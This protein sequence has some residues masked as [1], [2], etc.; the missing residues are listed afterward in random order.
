MFTHFIHPIFHQASSKRGTLISMLDESVKGIKAVKASSQESRRADEFHKPNE[1]LFRAEFRVERVW[2]TFTEMMGWVMG[3]AAAAVWLVG[4]RRI[5][6][7][8][9]QSRVTIGTLMAFVGYMALFYM[10]MRWFTVII[11]WMTHAMTSAERIFTVLGSAPELYEAPGAKHFERFEGRITFQDVHFSYDRG[12]E[13]IHGVGFDIAPREMIGLVGRSGAGKSTLINL[14]CRFYDV[15]SGVVKIDGHPIGEIRL[16]D[17]RRQIGMVMQEPFLFSASI[18]DNIRYAVPEASFEQV[19]E[20]AKAAHAHEF[21]LDKED[22]YDTVIGEGG[23]ALSGGE[24]QRVAIARA[25][26]HDPPI[27]ILD[28]ATSSVDSQ[29]ERAIQDALARLTQGRTTIAIAHRL[30]TLR[31]ASRLFV[32]DN[33]RVVEMGTHSE[34]IEQDGVYARLVKLQT[35]L[36][37][38]RATVWAE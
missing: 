32:V 4:G 18:L 11:N 24:Q 27:L 9:E 29:T 12:K 22:G 23:T 31:N 3:L 21:I 34:L 6:L 25:I 14:M 10:P 16:T 28:E 8:G 35:E 17:V 26:L 37:T 5:L 38:T 36:N 20:A 7:A 19:V 1:G 13:V 30:A 2:V 33:G 15:D